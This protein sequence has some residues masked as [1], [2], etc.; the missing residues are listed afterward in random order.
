[1]TYVY[2]DLPTCKNCGDTSEYCMCDKPNFKEIAK[3]IGLAIER[4]AGSEKEKDEESRFFHAQCLRWEEVYGDLLREKIKLQAQV[5][6]GRRVIEDIGRKHKEVVE[7]LR[8]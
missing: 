2:D 6:E 1:M 3:P 8:E 5:T 7:K 4:C